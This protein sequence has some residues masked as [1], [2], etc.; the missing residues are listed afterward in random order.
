MGHYIH[1]LEITPAGTVVRDLDFSNSTGTSPYY[2]R[3][4]S[5]PGEPRYK[6]TWVGSPLSESQR[7]THFIPD[8]T[9]T[10]LMLGIKTASV[11]ASI[12][13]LNELDK[14]FK[15]AMT[16]QVAQHK[17]LSANTFVLAIQLHDS[18]KRSQAKILSAKIPRPSNFFSPTIFAKYILDLR[19]TIKHDYFSASVHSLIEDAEIDNGS[20]NFVLIN[21]DTDEFIPG[22]QDAPLRIKVEGGDTST[23]RLMIGMRMTDDPED[24]VHHFWAKDATLS[25][26]TDLSGTDTSLDGDGANEGTITTPLDTSEHLTHQWILEDPV[27]TL[28]QFGFFR[29]FGVGKRSAAVFGARLRLGLYDGT[30]I[31]YADGNGFALD[32]AVEIGSHSGNDLALFD[33]G[34]V[35]VPTP[36]MGGQPVYG[37][38]Y[39]IHITCSN[40]AG[41]PTFTLDEFF[42]MPVLDGPEGSGF[43]DALYPIGSG[44]TGVQAF[45]VDAI[46][47]A[48]DAYPVNAGGVQTFGGVLT[49][50]RALYGKPATK[51][52]LF[53]CLYDGTNLRRRSGHALTV[54][55]EYE[56]RHG[57][58]IGQ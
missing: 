58:M 6:E 24:F 42:L 26:E 39:E 22:D 38:V 44:A 8:A 1:G 40:I 52:M 46:P 25:N 45:V 18:A 56:L 27:P 41:S 49:G 29:A 23:N 3:P 11:D 55:V 2:L 15:D 33:L 7:L 20:G 19:V 28:A 54:N 31:I 34:P 17:I 50:G 48:S 5:I 53:F 47:G 51:C 32:E 9:E 13:A 37:L 16:A 12:K 30:D 4:G 36:R 10:T 57:G 21:A 14:F 35:Y 43:V